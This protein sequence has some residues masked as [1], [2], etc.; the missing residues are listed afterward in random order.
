M[1]AQVTISFDDENDGPGAN[2]EDGFVVL[3]KTGNDPWDAANGI[4]TSGVTVTDVPGA[5]HNPSN[6][7]TDN[8]IQ[9]NLNYFYRIV[10]YRGTAWS[11]ATEKKAGS[12]V[13]PVRVPGAGE[14]GYPN[15]LPDDNSGVTY[16]LTHEPVFHYDAREHAEAR[17]YL[18]TEPLWAKIGGDLTPGERLPNKA[19]TYANNNRP[20]GDKVTDVVVEMPSLYQW[21]PDSANVAPIP[22]LGDRHTTEFTL[23]ASSS[24]YNMLK[25]SSK[26]GFNNTLNQKFSAIVN[27]NNNDCIYFSEGVSMFVVLSQANINYTA[28]PYPPPHSNPRLA[29]KDIS[30]NNDHDQN[31]LSWLFNLFRSPY[32]R[33]YQWADAAEYANSTLALYDWASGSDVKEHHGALFDDGG[34]INR[35]PFNSNGHTYREA[36]M[37][38]GLR[39]SHYYPSEHSLIAGVVGGTYSTASISPLEN[40]LKFTPGEDFPHPMLSSSSNATDNPAP[41]NILS[42]IHH[43]DDP[44]GAGNRKG[45]IKGWINGGGPAF[46]QVN[47]STFI[48]VAG[49]QHPSI[50][51]VINPSTFN[52]FT[53]NANI[54]E[55]LFFDKALV[56]SDFDNITAYLE[57]RYA[58]YLNTQTGY[59]GQFA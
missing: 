10:Y 28:H 14:L 22:V 47:P 53:G 30:S 7:H 40:Y 21:S 18:G 35:T 33:T 29:F 1:P 15:N 16:S 3:R 55:I 36:H 8:T 32:V 44:G 17:N 6:S 54:A 50:M 11:T 23:G 9:P 5:D 2:S 57:N 43:G 46:E 41:M 58:G 51:P 24:I 27:P 49:A 52:F 38:Q 56:K 25:P 42:F 39:Y 20:I 26:D 48:N 37:Y 34:G 19:D 59:T 45:Q 13:G 31:G 4:P 12:L